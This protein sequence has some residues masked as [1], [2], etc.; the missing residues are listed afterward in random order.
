MHKI[1]LLLLMNFLEVKNVSFV[2]PAINETLNYVNSTENKF[3]ENKKTSFF[4]GR[5]TIAKTRTRFF[6]FYK[7]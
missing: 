4:Y 1:S 2:P 3:Q 6:A 7:L 5:W